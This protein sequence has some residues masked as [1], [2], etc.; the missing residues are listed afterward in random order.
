M[1]SVIQTTQPG[2]LA[3]LLTSAEASL[4]LWLCGLS[5]TEQGAVV[6]WPPPPSRPHSTPAHRGAKRTPTVQVKRLVGGASQLS[7]HLDQYLTQCTT[8]PVNSF[9]LLRSY[10]FW[11]IKKKKESCL[12]MILDEQA[13]KLAFC[14]PLKTFSHFSAT[15]LPFLCSF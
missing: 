13:D 15:T 11:M 7:V 10:A 3:M 9:T 8:V 4:F 12:S 1:R 5:V 14:I 6:K 2:L